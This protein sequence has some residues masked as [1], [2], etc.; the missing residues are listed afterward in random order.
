MI[1]FYKALI[2]LIISCMTA[3]AQIRNNKQLSPQT[4]KPRTEKTLVGKKKANVKDPL[5]QQPTNLSSLSAGK[6]FQKQYRFDRAIA[7]YNNYRTA[8]VKKK[9]PTEEVDRLL[10][11]CRIGQN[12]LQGIENVCVID[13]FI[14]DKQHFLRAYNL[15]PES[16]KLYT[17]KAFFQGEDSCNST[18]YQTQLGNRILYGSTNSD[19]T[20]SIFSCNKTTEGWSDPSMLPENINSLASN[21]NYPFLLDDGVT[22]YFASDNPNS[23]GGYD[24]F[25]TRYDTNTDSYLKPENMGMPF[26][27]PSND[28]MLAIDEVNGLGWFASDRYQPEGKVCIYVF[29]PNSTKQIYDAKTTPMNKLIKLAQLKDIQA[30]WS[31]EQIVQ[32]AQA[33][34]DKLLNRTTSAKANDGFSFIIDDTHTYQAYS[35]F[36]SNEARETFKQLQRILME[37]D[38]NI[39]RLQELR[40][41]YGKGNSDDKKQLEGD[42]LGLERITMQRQKQIEQETVSVRNIEIKKLNQK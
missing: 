34:L 12:M 20:I 22:F 4:V 41:Q 26:N 21:A 8:L 17:Y 10:E 40:N 16:G 2:L 18:V 36:Q 3:S 14:V 25:V 9:Q 1:R 15:S 42:I 37:N 24:L 5:V 27:S 6:N 23:L 28:Y 29:V 38:K 31:D 35:D 13:S 11:Q 7:V 33:R 19:N 39:T 30:T 32:S